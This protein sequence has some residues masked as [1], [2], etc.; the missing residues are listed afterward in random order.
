MTVDNPSV[1]ESTPVP[2]EQLGSYP[3]FSQATYPENTASPE[4]LQVQLGA[5]YLSYI[6]EPPPL[7][8]GN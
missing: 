3:Q 5:A 7:Y 4:S 6:G 8:P 1:Q 2:S